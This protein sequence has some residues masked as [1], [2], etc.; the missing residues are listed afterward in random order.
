MKTLKVTRI[1]AAW[2][3]A[4]NACE[5]QVIVFEGEWPAGADI[6]AANI[7]RAVELKLDIDW[8]VKHVLT[9][10]AYAAYEKATAQAYAAYKKATAPA[11]YAAYK[12]AEALA[13]AAYEK[14]KA[15]AYAA[16]KK[17]KALAFIDVLA[18]REPQ[19]ATA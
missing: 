3:R 4:H 16:Y 17:A 10:L 19:A 9:A 7:M 12:K 14:A 6:T 15:P 5:E 2:L 1:D 13:Y 11:Y 18:P 8:L